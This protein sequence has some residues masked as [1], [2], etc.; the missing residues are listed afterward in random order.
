MEVPT[1]NLDSALMRVKFFDPC[2]SWSWYVQDWD[3]EDSCFGWVK[4]VEPEWGYFSLTELSEIKGP[5]GIGIEIDVYFT[6]TPAKTITN[7]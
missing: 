1:E 6:P 4:G 3:G 2:G 7:L 5:L